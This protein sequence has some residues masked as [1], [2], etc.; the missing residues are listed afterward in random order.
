MPLDAS[1]PAPVRLPFARAVGA[2]TALSLLGGAA[3]WY[4]LEIRADRPP[5]FD[6]G[7][8]FLTVE[9]FPVPGQDGRGTPYGDATA[10]SAPTTGEAATTTTAASGGVL[11]AAIPGAPAPLGT[12]PPPASSGPRLPT[13]GTY[14]YAVEGTEGATAF[15]SRSYPTRAGIVVHRDPALRDD[16]LVFDL[17]LSGQHEEREVV[18]TTA[19][20]LA[21]SFEAG[22]ITFGPGTQTSQAGYDPVMVQI[23]YPLGPGAQASGSSAAK[24]GGTVARVEDWTAKVVG[25][26]VLDVLGRQRTTWVVD[27]QRRTRPGGAEQVDRFRRYWYDPELGIWVRWTE[28]FDASR[29]LLV[30][31][32]YHTTYTATLVG[33]VPAG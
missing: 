23:P 28:R 3:G 4:Q 17:R 2:L 19:A 32:T 30:D 20:G 22:S 21:F 12:D 1:P 29:D 15:G 25:Q 14:T 16:E 7:G 33:F 6:R 8:A 5:S 9:D 13:V 24:D 31:F 10:T 11:P 27:V 18:R 26:E